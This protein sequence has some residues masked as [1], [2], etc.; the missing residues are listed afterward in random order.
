M[1]SLSSTVMV[2][3]LIDP[4]DWSSIRTDDLSG[5]VVLMGIVADMLADRRPRMRG[6]P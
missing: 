5:V 3:S 4:P 1:I 6:S 2:A